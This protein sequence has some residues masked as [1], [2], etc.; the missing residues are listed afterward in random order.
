MT[1]PDPKPTQVAILGA[2]PA[3][4]A[5]ALALHQGDPGISVLVVNR[6]GS[7][8]PRAAETLPPPAEPLLKQLRVWEALVHD[9]HLPSFGSAAAWGGAQLRTN[10]YLFH[11]SQRGWHLDRPRFD[12]MLARI[13]ADRGIP[14]LDAGGIDSIT[15]LSKTNTAEGTGWRFTLLPSDAGSPRRVIDADVVVDATGRRATFARNAG[16]RRELDDRLVAAARPF[17]MPEAFLESEHRS[18]VES[19]EHGWASL[20]WTPEGRGIVAFMTDDDLAGE[21]RLR[22]ESQWTAWLEHTPHLKSRLRKAR[23]LGPPEFHAAQSG[24][25]DRVTGDDWLAVGDA[26]S[27]LDPLSSMG[28]FKALRSGIVASYAIRDRRDG[29]ATGW[30]RFA[31]WVGR[32]YATYLRGRGEFYRAETR[33]PSAP[34]WRRR[35]NLLT[36]SKHDTCPEL[37]NSTFRE[38][39][40][41]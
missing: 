12:R 35:Q 13:A 30:A 38:P 21:A 17:E 15:R 9:G 11:P 28:V 27:T 41:S 2:G 7:R 24:L 33:W 23:A 8:H 4:L 34:F 3:G 36:F 18:L 25:L 5:T 10:D 26:A 19:F 31:S 39:L 1:L 20:G 16:A 14:I 32:E 6:A 22:S 29:I 37:E 40:L